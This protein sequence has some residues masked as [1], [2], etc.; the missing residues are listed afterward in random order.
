MGL[1]TLHNCSVFFIGLIKVMVDMSLKLFSNSKVFWFSPYSRMIVFW[2]SP[3]SRMVQYST[4]QY[5]TVL[6]C[7]VG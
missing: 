7:T 6:Y 1:F 5:C 4:V 3:Y 2:F